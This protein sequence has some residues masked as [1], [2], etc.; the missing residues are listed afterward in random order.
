MSDYIP[1]PVESKQYKRY[2]NVS[3]NRPYGDDAAPYINYREDNVV[4]NAAG[5]MTQGAGEVGMGITKENGNTEFPI[6]VTGDMTMTGGIMTYA[7][8]LQAL[9]SF[10]YHV[11][12]LRD[13]RPPSGP[14]RKT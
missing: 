14:G 6:L 9:D 1:T 3:M 11:A 8:L 12:Q 10:Y 13:E 5:E 2:R 4:S 7:E